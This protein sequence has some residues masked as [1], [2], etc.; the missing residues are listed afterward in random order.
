MWALRVVTFAGLT[1]ASRLALAHPASN[2]SD[3]HFAFGIAPTFGALIWT[4]KHRWQFEENGEAAK[5]ASVERR[6]FVAYGGIVRGGWLWNAGRSQVIASLYAAWQRSLPTAKNY[7]GELATYFVRS[8][9]TISSIGASFQVRLPKTPL[10]IGETLGIA[11]LKSQ[12]ERSNS[13]NSASSYYGFTAGVG[14]KW[15]V[16]EDASLAVEIGP[17]GE[18]MNVNLYALFPEIKQHFVRS[19]SIALE[20]GI[21]WPGLN[22]GKRR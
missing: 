5:I 11:H 3:S 22:S 4:A 21:Q 6:N 9:A 10:V 15:R 12:V 16:W 7:Q 18:F 17:R 8:F 13:Q 14:L 20:F 19:A 2:R 1:L